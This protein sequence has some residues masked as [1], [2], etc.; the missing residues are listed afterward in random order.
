MTDTALTAG[1][2][3]YLRTGNP[4]HLPPLPLAHL[5]PPTPETATDAAATAR[6]ALVRWHRYRHLPGVAGLPEYRAALDLAA[7]LNTPPPGLP[8]LPAPSRTAAPPR[9]RRRAWKRNAPGKTP[10]DGELTLGAAILDQLLF[11]RAL[12]DEDPRAADTVLTLLDLQTR[13]LREERT[14]PRER[15]ALLTDRAEIL[16]G[17]ARRPEDREHA[18]SALRCAD[19]AVDLTERHLAPDEPHLVHRLALRAR[20]AR[21]AAG[22]GGDPSARERAAEDLRRAADAAGAHRPM[23][24]DPLRDLA[25]L[26][27]GPAGPDGPAASPEDLA[28]AV[29][30]ARD[31]RLATDPGDER[32]REHRRLL[33]EVCARARPVLGEDAV[34][35]LSDPGE[36]DRTEPW[37]RTAD[38]LGAE[39]AERRAAALA[40]VETVPPGHPDRVPALLR[41]AEAECRVWETFGPEPRPDRARALARRAVDAALPGTPMAGQALTV[42]ARCTLYLAA[43][44]RDEIDVPLGEETVALI[45][46]AATALPPGDPDTPGTLNLLAELLYRTADGLGDRTLVPEAVELG[47]RA[48]DLTPADAPVRPLRL[49]DLAVLLE[50]AAGALDRSDLLVEAETL[51]REAAGLLPPGHPRRHELLYN[52]A[53]TVMQASATDRDRLPRLQ[54]AERLYREAWSLLPRDH[55]DQ[56]R[57]LSSVSQVLRLRHDVT[58]DRDCLAEAVD[59][60]RR[61]VRLTPPGAEFRT[62]RQI[63]LAR[64]CTALHDLTEDPA[65]AA[66]LREEALAAWD[67]VVADENQ[68]FGRRKEAH[69]QRARLAL[70]AGRPRIA[71]RALEEVL[72][73]MP[74]TLRRHLSGPDRLGGAERAPQIAAQAAVVA[75]RCGRPGHAVELLERGRAVLYSEALTG[76][77]VQALLERLDP[78]AAERLRELDSELSRADFMAHVAEVRTV[79]R[80][81]GFLGRTVTGDEQ[82]HDPR[83]GVAARIRR[84]AVEREDLLRRLALTPEYAEATRRPALP[85]LRARI[86]GHTAVYVLADTDGGHALLVPAD[87]AEDVTHIPLPRLTSAAADERAAQARRAVHDAADPALGPGRRAAAQARLHT[88]LEWLWDAVAE[89]VLARVPGIG[90]GEPP[91]LWWCPV[92]PVVRLPLHAAGR[93]IRPPAV[94]GPPPT[95]VDRVIPS[96]VTTLGALAHTL[97]GA[98]EPP[99]REGALVVAVRRTPGLPP[100]LQARREAETVLARI[101]GSRLLLDE[102]ADD[103][104]VRHALREHAVVHFACHG[105]NDQYLS[106]LRGGGLHL[107]S[108]ATLPASVIQNEPLDHGALAFLSACS[109]AEP[110]PKRPDEPMHLAAAFQIAGFRSVIGTLWQTPDTPR[111]AHEVYDALTARGTRPPDTTA[112]A[113]ALADAVRAVRDAYPATP[114]LWAPYLHM[115]A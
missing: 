100:L 45:R 46:R 101:P 92:G 9:G 56:P 21:A 95:V 12:W 78:A 13:A 97:R 59:L 65:Q 25:L 15:A 70:A 14:S 42:L 84:L 107:A 49:S 26:L 114:T 41:A 112:A 7:R 60:A 102:E 85:E 33:A 106:G 81:R 34:A 57:F 32:A 27:S 2:D 99:P 6:L 22:P 36:P 98:P 68:P 54:E 4:A 62:E 47:R 90:D 38:D 8:P 23:I 16:L 35:R 19:L 105:D 55:P 30:A 11:L 37:W 91:R 75:I 17:L 63:L 10:S 113:S 72:D 51:A 74:R 24:L 64:P 96:C 110:H 67:A 31:L 86:A 109:T 5:S 88:V 18:E 66:A 61:A 108:G 77:R 48:L 93:H 43:D 94:P 39:P 20:C 83:P 111:M 82:I 52:L 58:G 73:G 76:R 104:T 71:L 79:V 80:K 69:R 87:P 50:S 89:P 28:E 29:R 1:L 40:L 115:G 103:T 44:E 53:S 3:R